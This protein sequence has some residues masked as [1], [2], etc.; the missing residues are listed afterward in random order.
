[1]SHNML[2]STHFKPNRIITILAILITYL[3]IAPSVYAIGAGRFVE[4]PLNENPLGDIK[5]G[6]NSTPTFVDID[7]DGDLDLFSGTKFGVINYFQNTGS[8]NEPN[9]VRQ[10][11]FDS[12]LP[13]IIPYATPTFGDL[14]ND[15]D[16]DALS[17]FTDGEIVYFENIGS[18]NSP[19]F[20]RYETNDNANPLKGV[21]VGDYSAPTLVD[22]DNDGDLDVFIGKEG[23]TIKYFNN[24]GGINGP[25]FVEQTG[26]DN[27]FQGTN[28]GGNS[29]PVF[30]DIDNDNDLDAF[31]GE[32]LGT[33]QYFENIGNMNA[34]NF[35]ERT[36]NDNPFDGEDVGSYSAPTLVDI[37][38]DGDLDAFCGEDSGAISYFNNIG[39]ID[40]PIFVKR[41][42]VNPFNEI[43]VGSYSSS[44]PAVADIDGDNDL[45][46]F[47]GKYNG[48]QYFENIGTINKPQF[49]ERTNT[50]NPLNEIDADATIHNSAPA[51]ADINNDGDLDAL[52]GNYD[53]TIIYFENTG[54]SNTPN[55]VEQSGN[56][57]PWD[58]IDVGEYSTPTLADIDQDGDLDLF[59]G[60]GSDNARS[61]Q[62]FENTGNRYNPI[63]A[64]PG[65]TDLIG[66][67]GGIERNSVASFL[68]L[69]EDGDLDLITGGYYG[70]LKYFENTGDPNNL[71]KRRYGIFNQSS[72]GFYTAPVVTDIDNDGHLD[73]FIGTMAGDI[74]HYWQLSNHPPVHNLPNE[75]NI[76]ED[77]AF[78][79]TDENQITINDPDS[80]NY[81]PVKVT[82][83]AT[84]GFITLGST[85]DL[86]FSSGD[87]EEDTEMTFQG[88]LYHD[89]ETDTPKDKINSALQN[90]T[91]MPAPNFHGS[92]TLQITT[93]DQG[94]TGPGPIGIDTDTINIIVTPVADTPSI[95]N[96]ATPLGIQNSSG[97]VITR[98]PVDG[99][100]VQYYKI[101]NIT[102]GHLFQNDGTTPINND[103]FITIIEGAAGLKFTP[104]GIGTGSFFVQAATANNNSSIGGDIVVANITISVPTVTVTTHGSLSESNP[105]ASASFDFTLDSPAPPGSLTVNYTVTS[106]N[107]SA[108]PDADYTPTLPGSLIF[109]EGE[110]TKQVNIN[111]LDDTIPD[112]NEVIQIFLTP[113]INYQ[114]T[115][116]G[117]S[118]SL[119]IQDNDFN[120]V[121]SLPTVTVNSSGSLSE[122]DSLTSAM[123]EFQLNSPLQAGRLTVNYTVT[124]GSN[125]ASPGL[126]YTPILPGQVI[127]NV[128]EMTQQLLINVIDDSEIESNETIQV[129]LTPNTN[130]NIEANGNSALLTIQDNDV[131]SSAPV[132]EPIPNQ[133]IMVSNTLQ[134]PVIA[135]DAEDHELNYTLNIGPPANAMI[136]QNSGEFSWTPIQAGNYVV[137]VQVTEIDGKQLSTQT[138]FQILVN[139]ADTRLDL[140]L[141]SNA[142]FKNGQL[143]VSGQLKHFPINENPNFIL[144]LPIQLQIANDDTQ[145]IVTTLET[146]TTT[147]GNYRFT[148]LPPFAQEGLYALQTQF[149][150]N[151]ALAPATSQAQSLIVRNLAGYALLIQGR[152]AGGAGL[153]T[154][155]K[156]LNRVY[157]RMKAR[158]FLDENIEYFNYNTDQA[159]FSIEVDGMPNKPGIQAALQRLQTKMNANP[160]PLFIVMVDH[161]GVDGSFYLDNGDGETIMPAELDSWLTTLET[162]LDVRALA[163]PRTTIIGACYSGSFIPTLSKPGRVIVTSTATDEESY[164][165]PKE[166]DEIRSGEFFME[167][168][169][170]QLGRGNS[171]KKS[172]ELAT[173]S[174]ESLTMLHGT[175]PFNPRYQDRAVQHPLLDDNSD[176]QGSNVFFVGED[177]LLAKDIYLGLGR[178]SDA[179]V[180]GNSV[181]IL[182]V[183]PTRYLE[184]N[185]SATELFATINN[186]TRVMGNQVYV[187]IRSP[188]ITL[189]RNGIEQHEQL[190]INGLQRTLLMLASGDRFTRQFAQFHEPGKYELLYFAIDK[191]TGELSPIKRSVAYKNKPGNNPPAPFDLLEPDDDSETATNLLLDWEDTFDPDGDQ[192]TYTLILA[193]DPL[194]QHEIYRQ[195]EQFLTMTYIDE[196]T[197][198]NDALNQNQPGLRDG[199]T[200]Y[201][202]V[203]AID[204]YGART[205]SPIFSFT[206]NNTNAPPSIA[207]LHVSSA[208]NFTSLDN[209]V[210]DFWQLDAFGNPILDAFG[211]PMPVA[212]PPVIHQEPGFYNMLLPFGRRRVTINQPGMEPQEFDL[213]NTNGQA[214]LI[215]KESNTQERIIELDS[216]DGFKNL[217]FA[218]KSVNRVI[219]HHG[220]LQF[221]VKQTRLEE[222]Q[223]TVSLI[224]NRTGGQ[225]GKVSVSYTTLDGSARAESDYQTANGTLTWADGDSLSKRIP[226]TIL[227]DSELEGDEDLT[228]LLYEPTGGAEL[229]QN[230]QIHITI[231]DDDAQSTP[232]ETI[233]H[234][235]MQ[236]DSISAETNNQEESSLSGE[237]TQEESHSENQSE[238][239]SDSESESEG[240]SDSEAQS[241]GDENENQSEGL[242]KD[243]LQFSSSTYTADE[244]DGLLKTIT[245]TR[246]GNN[247]GEISALY[248]TSSRSTATEGSDY[249]GEFGTITWA[250]NDLQPKILEIEI[251]DDVEV[252]D[253][254]SIHLMLFNATGNTG[255][256]AQTTLTIID[257]DRATTTQEPIASANSE[258]ISTKNTSLELATVQFIADTYI[259]EEGV[260]PLTTLSV[261]RQGSSQGE[262]SVQYAPTPKST[263]TLDTDYTGGTGTLIWADSDIQPKPILLTLIDDEDIEGAEFVQFSLFDPKGDVELG[264]MERVM[265]IITDNE[266]ISQST[267]EASPNEEAQPNQE[268][269][270]TENPVDLEISP[271]SEEFTNLLETEN[272]D[273]PSLGDGVVLQ[274]PPLP[275]LGIGVVIVDENAS[276]TTLCSQEECEV[277]SIFLGGVS[278]NGWD[279]QNP[280][281]ITPL[282]QIWIEAEIEVDAL[283]VGQPADILIGALYSPDIAQILPWW[284]I[285]DEQWGIV[286]WDGELDHLLAASDNITLTPTQTV[287][288]YQGPI[289][290]G[291]LQVFFGYRLENGTIV[292]NGEQAIEIVVQP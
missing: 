134:L 14:D 82:L 193:S 236:E 218:M 253:T 96:A 284:L 188:N 4:V 290:E 269:Q 211:N 291:Y 187:D 46:V 228:L 265:L 148:N 216:E 287:K 240:H 160:G 252:E 110:T 182:T 152:T 270:P 181:D 50:A 59:I 259:T 175:T 189:T 20:A 167:A 159:K 264:K 132:I 201:W 222:N 244:N 94:F 5:A 177:G 274:K 65:T 25:S 84:G 129:L 257:N 128:G 223:T 52:I 54:N 145:E 227:N 30:G 194:F 109:N 44:I 123:F 166:P 164:K 35:V 199:T 149:A 235:E 121:A 88:I 288:I 69:D 68:D 271:T 104:T 280:I 77:N 283:H 90:M 262:I 31:I 60:F 61:F 179:D 15:G 230:Q 75:V 254:E 146:Q 155:N 204:W 250:H 260:G 281:Q 98:N 1:M 41:S 163:Q 197:P 220:Q 83:L 36:G 221:S 245:I 126:D 143:E 249:L 9:F 139:P 258:A 85:S 99:D 191:E 225:D 63:F 161:G 205:T 130:Y 112:P 125:S 212:Q 62:Y 70:T 162:G 21:D 48:L 74:R 213:D 66:N 97:L 241:G 56:D 226:F 255:T 185:Q 95:T 18:P 142:I 58:G 73:I 234:E 196:Q 87:G 10:S 37:D 12:P 276:R 64:G 71:F 76:P 200:Y 117:S 17:G 268:V 157:R 106:S 215:L 239:F 42:V 251:I 273:L 91:F 122:S 243:S 190:E 34:P 170:A 153:A 173:Q 8:A 32:K 150:G 93:N 195:E 246:T 180:F 13:K 27:P 131:F 224:V 11:D 206:T 103:D 282:Q 169:F 105:S 176:G 247:Q 120:T 38:L 202:K 147:A 168:F 80:F 238:D 51:I 92:A 89:F 3:T 184:I 242:L 107:L 272:L 165:G 140:N 26:N 256:L 24:I 81:N 102:N 229:G 154:H 210:I 43:D 2:T 172:F 277:N 22:I 33:I 263:A 261:I 53:G 208:V 135:F 55:F 248:F 214:K 57:N 278:F 233:A 171:L 86:T 114:F 16:F 219:A 137:T 158:D 174:T 286:W 136:D 118:A 266:E 275:D 141:S 124:T 115:G 101:F 186:P 47:I 183:T 292:F 79:F 133:V 192:M 111:V 7:N 207:S 267:V 116:T 217:N 198:V 6:A 231:I 237:E 45:D 279:Y 40:N 127:F 29:T 156:S 232:V 144:G 285:K 67:R 100:E 19:R 28:T 138:S 289:S 209:A 72:I 151:Q 23:G 113:D 78:I 203:E 108:T 49:E 178:Q 39:H 119:T